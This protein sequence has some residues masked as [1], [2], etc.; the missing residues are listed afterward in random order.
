MSR[1]VELLAG[2]CDEAEAA[3]PEFRVPRHT[4][5]AKLQAIVPAAEAPSLNRPEICHVD[6]YLAVACATGNPAAITAFTCRHTARLQDYLR[7]FSDSSDLIDEVRA[8]LEDK[9]LLSEGGFL[10]RIAQYEGR[11]PL[12]SWVTVAAKRCLLSILRARGRA[13]RTD[14]IEG[15]WDLWST[16]PSS[17]HS[18]SQQYAATIKESLRQAIHSLTVRERTILRLSIIENVSL[19]QIARMLSINQSTVSRAFHGS[20]DKVNEEVRNRL[21]ALHGMQDSEIESVVRDLRSRADLSLS[22]MFA[23]TEE[24][25]MS[26]HAQA[27]AIE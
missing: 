16:V 24:A 15:L 12:G 22:R 7:R 21:K 2:L 27:K 5:L 23:D 25:P 1:D 4:F 9:L 20:L 11:G 17:A 3:W 19:S 26:Q 10:P 8:K 14:P 18:Q 6:L 13:P